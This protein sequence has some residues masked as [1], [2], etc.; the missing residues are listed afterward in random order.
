MSELRAALE[1]ALGPIYR[2]EREVRPV[3]NCRLFVAVGPLTDPEL[4]VKVLPG[5]L[6]LAVDARVFERELILLADRLGHAQL[7]APRGAGRAGSI[8]YH[9]RRFIEGTTLRAWLA[10]HGELPLRRTVDI[11]RDVLV[12]LAHAHRGSIAHGDLKP[13]NVL[14]A[15]RQVLVA[16]TGIVDALT[17]ALPSGVAGAVSAAL[18]APAY[19]SPER[20]NGGA[21]TGPR[22]DIF[23]VGVLLHEMLTGQPPAIQAESLEE[24]R[25][26]PPWLAE[27]ARR[28]LTPE[29]A[30]R[31]PDAA[32][33]L[34]QV[35]RPNSETV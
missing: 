2:V 18:C 6:S 25:S 34:E 3:G 31:W 16:D 10:N 13:E 24:V 23:A 21:P 20:R 11:L 7:V 19:V 14:L 12:A 9:S 35:S 26:L 27:L 17:R 30:E 29:P 22:D 15:G 32:A 1:D 5:E 8:V 28:C 33:A 4:L